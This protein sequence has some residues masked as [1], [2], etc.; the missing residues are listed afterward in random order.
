MAVKQFSIRNIPQKVLDTI[1]A[2]AELNQNLK[3]PNIV[4][5][6]GYIRQEAQLYFVLEF[7]ENGSLTSIM[8]TFGPFPEV[9]ARVYSEQ[10]LR[11]LQYLHDRG[12]IHRDI[13][14][15]NIL[16]AKDGT[17]KLAD[18]GVSAKMSEQDKRFSVV[19]TP[20]WMAPE[21]I[22]MTGHHTTSDI[23]SLA[24]TVIELLTGDPPYFELQSMSALFKIVSDPHPPLPEGITDLLKDFLLAS[25]IKDP[26]QR[27]SAV[28]LLE[29][30]WIKTQ[31]VY[32]PT[33][34]P[35]QRQQSVM[36]PQLTD[37]GGSEKRITSLQQAEEDISALREQIDELN[38]RLSS[39]L[40]DRQ[41]ALDVAHDCLKATSTSARMACEQKLGSLSLVGN[42]ATTLEGEAAQVGEPKLVRS[43]SSFYSMDEQ[44][45]FL[46]YQ[47]SKE[48]TA[49]H[50]QKIGAETSFSSSS[51]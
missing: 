2:E 49:D 14:G 24:C 28:S 21:V 4:K 18:F 42:L 34:T 15:C 8:K 16:V 32:G 27:P 51:S 43:K 13:K 46:D 26:L 37:S 17:V 40:A 19:G 29:H 5:F 10:V 44:D 20:Y 33:P 1:M 47:Y 50:L 31:S 7:V 22:E 39:A 36:F 12:I 41:Q 48:W 35:L 11:G 3:H 25:F 23:W 45:A 30:G 9:L 6:Q 38:G